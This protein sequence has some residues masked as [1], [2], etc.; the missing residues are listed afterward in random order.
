MV[1]FGFKSL[2][3]VSSAISGAESMHAQNF[4]RGQPYRGQIADDLVRKSNREASP[5]KRAYSQQSYTVG[6]IESSY[7][8]GFFPVEVSINVDFQKV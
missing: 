4:Q 1:N 7:S 8:F 6:A 2:V 5:R 3:E